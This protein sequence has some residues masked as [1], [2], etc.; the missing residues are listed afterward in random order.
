RLAPL[1]PEIGF[2]FQDPATSFNPL[3]TIAEC[4][5]EP[6]IVHGRARSPRAAR[7][8]VDALLD[9]GRL[10]TAFGDRFPHELSGGQRQRASLA[11]ALALQPTL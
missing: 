3:L 9:A 2:V 6:L 7:A 11:R 5:A 8:R 4:I 10:P 1:R